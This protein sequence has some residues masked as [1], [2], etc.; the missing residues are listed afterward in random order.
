MNHRRVSKR[1]KHLN[2]ALFQTALN[3]I[4]V[5]LVEVVA[6]FCICWMCRNVT[7]DILIIKTGPAE[8]SL[9]VRHGRE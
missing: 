6:G 5:G 1:D 3:A 7:V 4:K 8:I 2:V 9:L